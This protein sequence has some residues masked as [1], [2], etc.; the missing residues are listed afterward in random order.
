[1][2]KIT[3]EKKDGLKEYT[4]TWQVDVSAATPREAALR[5]FEM[6]R[7]PTSRA[8]VFDVS[9]YDDQVGYDP[10]EAA[11]RIDVGAECIDCD[12]TGIV[13]EDGEDQKPCPSCA[14]AT[15]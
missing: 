1:M 5:A 10:G 7:D 9:L 15:S 6:Q 3:A 8:T 11:I 2:I 12:G 14:E 4:V 13:A